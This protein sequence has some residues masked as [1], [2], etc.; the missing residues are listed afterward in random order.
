[1]DDEKILDQIKQLGVVEERMRSMRT[2]LERAWFVLDPP[3][4][5]APNC[6]AE[7][8]LE[9][10]RLVLR[11]MDNLIPYASHENRYRGNPRSSAPTP[12]RVSPPEVEETYGN[13]SSNGSR[14]G[15]GTSH[16]ASNGNG[17]G[18]HHGWYERS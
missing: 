4:A 7:V 8:R 10:L 5:D 6:P 2:M 12:L 13:R 1:M 14:N 17:N 16:A 15:Q 11:E 18:R 3:L 9:D